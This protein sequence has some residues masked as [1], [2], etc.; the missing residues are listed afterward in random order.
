MYT[1][2]GFT[3]LQKYLYHVCYIVL[4]EATVILR[5]CDKIIIKYEKWKQHF[6]IIMINPGNVTPQGSCYILSVRGPFLDVRI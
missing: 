2:S 3:N 6:V 4:Y 1:L 5:N